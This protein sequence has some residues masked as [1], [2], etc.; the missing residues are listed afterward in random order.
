MFREKPIRAPAAPRAITVDMRQ[1]SA[2]FGRAL[3]IFGTIFS[4]VCL[5]LALVL[6]V[7]ALSLGDRAFLGGAA[8]VSIIGAVGLVLLL[9]GK[10]KRAK[11]LGIFRDGTEA[12]G[13]VLSVHH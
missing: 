8:M 5:G 2:N 12:E 7:L 1:D 10:Q 6:T 13:E 3:R 11:A 9:L 4:S